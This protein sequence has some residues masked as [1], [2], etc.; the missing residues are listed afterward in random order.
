MHAVTPVSPNDIQGV[1]RTCDDAA[2][3]VKFK[4]VKEKSATV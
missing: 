2:N 4:P 1:Q 3:V